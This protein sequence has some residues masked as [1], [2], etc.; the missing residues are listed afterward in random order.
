[1]SG[2]FDAAAAAALARMAPAEI[3]A[4]QD[5]LLAAHVRYAA[6]HAP[7]YRE[8]FAAAGIDPGEIRGVAD[9]PRLP[10]TAKADLER[11]NREFLCVPEEEVVDLCLTSGTTGQPVAML[12]TRRDLERLAHNEEIS[13]RA[14]GFTAGDRVLIAAAIDRCFMAG[15]AYFLGLTAL[16]CLV[17]RGGSSSVAMLRELVRRHRPTA[18]VGVP[19]LML[20]VGESLAAEGGDPAA[21][22]VRRIVGIGEP[23]RGADLALLPLG[24]RLRERWGAA[25][26]G[27]YAS[28]EMATAFCDCEAGR[29][30]HLHPGL[31]VVEI[32]DE[33][34]RPVAPGTPGEVVATPLRV[35]GMPLLRF[36]TG[37]VAT[38]HEE[39]CPCGRTTPR[40]GPVV[41]RKAQMLKVRG[42][43]LYPPAIFAVLQ[44]HPAVSGYY[45]EVFREYALA[46][47]VRV[48]VG[49]REPR[50]DAAALADLIA[51]RT[52]VKPE[53]VVV[54]PEE[55][56]RKT[57]LEGK[58]KPVLFFDYREGTS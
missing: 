29:G 51:A 4:R 30:G 57:V 12:Q 21:L 36:R 40:L 39:P 7:F 14:A 54:E 13:F 53:V 35:T 23:V 52:R 48:V 11:H 32:V 28:T 46:D 15:L 10:F 2:P 34:G 44:E 49:A 45:L 17:I 50:P 9:L 19:T 20:A 6:T 38:L 26:S 27:T 43:T 42:T 41:G 1:V 8:R 47:R 55:I 22:G 25:V 18:M 3:R 56:T 33:E 58:R 37:D 31:M 24:E 16:G 5:A